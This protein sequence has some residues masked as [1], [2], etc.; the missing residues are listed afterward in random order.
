M[1]ITALGTSHGNHTMTRNNTST[2]IETEGV[3]YLV[4]CG[5][6]V[7]ATLLRSGKGFAHIR[8]LFV[9]HMHAD[10]VGGLAEFTNMYFKHGDEETRQVTYC[11]PSEAV[12]PIRRYLEAIYMAPELRPG[13]LEL[14]GV[15]AGP[16]YEDERLK[17]TAVPNGHLGGAD[18]S[19]A[20][21]GLLNQGQSYGYIFELEG[22]RIAFSGDLPRDLEGLGELTAEPLDLLAMEMTHIKPEE[23]LPFVAAK[24]I[25]KLLLIHIHDP[26]HDEG[27]DVLRDMCFEYLDFPF[28][29]AHDGTQLEV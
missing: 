27:E 25:K 23:A 13:K 29:I 4:D 1:L 10:H 28:I 6:P 3:G 19:H 16:C 17:A 9:T 20:K 8:A 21:L 11:L 12:E 15:D 24:P 22:K 18:N 5:E 26:W 7:A 2:L 14:S